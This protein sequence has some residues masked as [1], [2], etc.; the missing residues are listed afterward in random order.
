MPLYLPSPLD[1]DTEKIVTEVIDCALEVHRQLGPGLLESI[2]AE[3]LGL[4]L[5]HRGLCFEREKPVQIFYREKALRMQRIDLIVEARVLIEI[6]A[7]DRLHPVHRAQV[8]SYL[9]AS[10]LRI[11]LLINFNNDL[12]KGHVKRIIL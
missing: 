4:E 2:Y 6:K 7:V 12:L 8:L 11:G 5:E 1:D 10:G 9:L 3:A